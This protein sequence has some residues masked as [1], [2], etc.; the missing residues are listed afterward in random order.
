MRRA[1]GLLRL[2]PSP[3]LLPAPGAV[4]SAAPAAFSAV[5]LRHIHASAS[6][7]AP[8]H[9]ED[10]PY[11]RCEGRHTPTRANAALHASLIACGT[12]PLFPARSAHTTA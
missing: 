2:L 6:A 5:I 12:P 8:I 9:I 11:C 3:G 1:A 10:E 7:P 4:Q